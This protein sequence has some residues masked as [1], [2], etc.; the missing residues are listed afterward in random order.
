MR[1]IESQS[2]ISEERAKQVKSRGGIYFDILEDFTVSQK[3]AYSFVKV[4]H[5]NLR[6]LGIMSSK[7]LQKGERRLAE[8]HTPAKAIMGFV[9]RNMIEEPT[10]C[11][12]LVIVYHGTFWESFGHAATFVRSN[13]S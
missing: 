1:L 12:E 13:Q 5:F 11:S 8:E 3:I 6:D 2:R 9:H 10:R 4:A 7:L